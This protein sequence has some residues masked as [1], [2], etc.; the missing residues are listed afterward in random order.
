M[1]EFIEKLDWVALEAKGISTKEE[2]IKLS[3][4]VNYDPEMALTRINVIKLELLFGSR[5]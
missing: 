5:Q 1:E 4:L 3:K 2:A